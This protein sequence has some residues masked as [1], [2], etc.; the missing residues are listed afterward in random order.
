MKELH[1]FEPGERLSS[2][3]LAKAQ[4]Q[5]GVFLP[6]DYSDVV[7]KHDGGSNPDE[8][9]FDY[10]IDGRTRVGN[11]GM[12]LSLRKSSSENVFETI[13]NLAEQLPQGVI[14][15][16]DTGSGDFVCLDYRAGAPSVVYF[17][18]ERADGK[19]IIHLAA[20]F[21]E[22]VDGLREPVDE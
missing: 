22:F 13:E 1:W 3:E 11:F 9:S 4:A 8:C 15:V 10:L 20:S 21:G 16:I 19:A 6:A 17:A 18:H 7:M 14:P 5:L 12:L 2:D